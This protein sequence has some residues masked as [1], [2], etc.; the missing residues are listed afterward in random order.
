MCCASS[1]P[2]ISSGS[3]TIPSLVVFAP[4][5]ATDTLHSR[6]ASR[7]LKPR[8]AGEGRTESYEEEGHEQACT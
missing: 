4:E 1:W 8:T 2:T 6:R 7:R 5:A 3:S